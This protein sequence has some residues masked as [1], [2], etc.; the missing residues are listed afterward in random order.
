MK[1]SPTV[2]NAMTDSLDD[3]LLID[4][5]YWRKE[6]WLEKEE[7][8]NLKFGFGIKHIPSMKYLKDNIKCR[9]Q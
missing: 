6:N 9:S 1:T 8:D 5:W 3:Q 4:G 2:M 7:M